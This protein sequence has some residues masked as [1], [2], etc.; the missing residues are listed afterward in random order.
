MKN[1]G[2]FLCRLWIACAVFVSAVGFEAEAFSW[3]SRARDL[4]ASPPRQTQ[5]S[6]HDS[7]KPLR[8]G[9]RPNK[10]E[11]ALS[12][13]QALES[14]PLCHRIAARLLVNNCQLLDG[15][16]E[17]TVLTDSG[18]LARDFVDSFAASLA[19]CDLERG[20]FLIP[21][22][23]AL[24]RESAL[25]KVPA[26]VKPHLHVSAAQVDKCLQGLAQ[27]D[28]AWNTW[29]SYRHKA[30]RFCEAARSEN[31]K[32]QNIHLYER[33]TKI[34]AK[35]TD[36]VEAE[37]EIR[38]HVLDTRL[39]DTASRLDRIAPHVDDLRVGLSQVEKIVSE[40][41]AHSAEDTAATV[42]DGLQEARNLRQLLAALLATVAESESGALSQHHALQKASNQAHNEL[43]VVLTSLQTAT[44]NAIALQ[45]ELLESQSRA[46]EISRRQE[47]IEAG[48]E[49][50]AKLADTLAIKHYGHQKALSDAQES[51]EQVLDTLESV[52]TSAGGLRSSM[53]GL[54]MTKWW[55]YLL[56]P[57]TTL[58]VGSYGL[59]PSAMR[60]ML[61]LG[62]GEA[63]GFI[64]TTANQYTSSKT[65]TGSVSAGLP[66]NRSSTLNTAYSI[67]DF[68]DHDLR[69]R[70]Y[71]ET[72]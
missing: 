72:F 9:D 41:I 31:E 55:P 21:K 43:S 29:V 36:D 15:R 24:F 5:T 42:R 10:Y 63:A 67:D 70:K 35:L 25:A 39:A 23:C 50:L 28:S 18:R 14:E 69:R 62:L 6:L 30:L 66:L 34:L 3:G 45:Q 37:L 7:P 13:L 58:I 65:S 22:D 68:T 53:S 2:G 19:I 1:P 26:P 32:D 49:N 54:S 52:S 17:A 33:I 59:P 38:L 61:L 46:D 16:D 51:V 57:V 47:T 44:V 20:S 12:E 60:N 8:L 48:M 27:S 64:I 71:F 56:C 40:A 4:D 11:I